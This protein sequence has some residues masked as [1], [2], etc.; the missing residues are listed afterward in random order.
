VINGATCN[1]KVTSGCDQTPA[2]VDVGRQ[3][4]G[5][6]AVDRA[7]DLVYVS[8]YLDDTVSVINGATCNGTV[9]SGCHQSPPTIPAGGSPAGLVV[10]HADHTV[11]AADN[12]FGA[13]SFFHFRAPGTP[14]RVTATASRGDVE[15]TWQAPADGGLPILY[16]VIPSPACPTCHGLSTPPTSGEPFT[17]I[18]GPHRGPALHVHGPGHRRR[19]PRTRVGTLQPRHPLNRSAPCLQVCL[20][21]PLGQAAKLTL[22]ARSA[23]VLPPG[24]YRTSERTGAP[25]SA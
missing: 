20:L 2:H 21:R 11:Y 23:A 5:F 17:T 18:T 7:T 10:N 6:V 1:G 4:F 9:T 8:N 13:V 12:G 25:H 22:T 19:R 24:D 14:T 16:R 3:G 15:L